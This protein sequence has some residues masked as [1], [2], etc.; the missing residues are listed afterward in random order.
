MTT[1]RENDRVRVRETCQWPHFAGETGT[2]VSV[3]SDHG[4]ERFVVQFDEP[5][6]SPTLSNPDLVCGRVTAAASDLERV[7]RFAVGDRVRY[8][9][10]GHRYHNLIGTVDAVTAK[11]I[12]VRYDNGEVWD[13]RPTSPLVII[14]E[15]EVMSEEEQSQ[16][17]TSSRPPT[18][19]PSP[20]PCSNAARPLSRAPLFWLGGDDED[21]L[22]LMLLLL[23]PSSKFTSPP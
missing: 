21:P 18:S 3:E 9:Q 5:V 11:A 19:R 13:M 2:V 17:I 22:T 12:I 6:P 16:P 8:E 10:E 23:L 7:G 1:F 14:L 20:G 4:D 15:D